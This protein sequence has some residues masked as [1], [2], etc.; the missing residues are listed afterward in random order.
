MV[1]FRVPIASRRAPASLLLTSNRDST[2]IQTSGRVFENGMAELKV[3]RICR[4][5]A[6]DFFHRVA[7]IILSWL[8]GHH[9]R[10][11]TNVPSSKWQR[12]NHLTS[13][14][15][16]RP[17]RSGRYVLLFSPKEREHIC[18]DLS[19]LVVHIPCGK[20]GYTFRVEP[21][22]SF[23]DSSAESAMGTI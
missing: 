14:I 8:R 16:Y 9:V 1:R 21:F 13:I 23:A 11:R 2:S 18:V 15:R 22:T 3:R 5:F 19:G 10:S 20:P 17:K 6:F 4:P 7:G 12:I